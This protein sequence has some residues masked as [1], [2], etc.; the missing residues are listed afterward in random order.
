[1]STKQRYGNAVWEAISDL[2]NHKVGKEHEYVSVGE[3]ANR[4]GVSFPTAKKYLAAL[5]EMGDVTVAKVG[6]VTGFRAKWRGGTNE[7]YHD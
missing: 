6:D 4:A 2:T 7:A 1:M 5:W 3:V